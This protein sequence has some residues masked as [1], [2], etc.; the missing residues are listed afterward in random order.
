ML[1]S[2]TKTFACL[3][4]L[5]LKNLNGRYF[6]MVKAITTNSAPNQP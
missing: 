2:I 1:S 6:K 5:A 4:Y 3:R